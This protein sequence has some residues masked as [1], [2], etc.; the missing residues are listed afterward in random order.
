MRLAIL[1]ALLATAPALAQEAPARS[2]ATVEAPPV[3]QS[4]S[5]SDDMQVYSSDGVLVAK[6]YL[7]RDEAYSGNDS[8]FV[9]A[10]HFLLRRIYPREAYVD[11][12]VVRLRMTAA[13][14]G[15]RQQNPPDGV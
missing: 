10:P 5:L 14:F 2:A 12:S 6:T 13:Q 9:E 3:S 1:A 4:I 15:A 7:F 8:F 11:G